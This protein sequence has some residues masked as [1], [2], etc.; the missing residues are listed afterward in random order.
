MSSKRLVFVAVLH[1]IYTGLIFGG[2]VLYRKSM[3]F[4]RACR[5]TNH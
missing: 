2:P 1:V 5:H 3:R 4:A